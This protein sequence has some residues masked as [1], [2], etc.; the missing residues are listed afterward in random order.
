MLQITSRSTCSSSAA[1]T[2]REHSIKALLAAGPHHHNLF[3]PMSKPPVQFAFGTLHAAFRSRLQSSP[4]L[5]ALWSKSSGAN[6]NCPPTLPMDISSREKLYADVKNEKPRL[7][8]ALHLAQTMAYA[9][10]LLRFY[11]CGISAVW[12]NTK[13]ARRLRRRQYKIGPFLDRTGND[14]AI[15]V[16]R[17]RVL[18]GIMAQTLYMDGVQR[19]SSATDVIRHDST[20]E[21]TGGSNGGLFQMLRRDFQLLHRAPQDTAK[22]PLF[23]IV[24]T[25]FGEMTPLLCWAVPEIMPLTC[26]LPLLLPRV[27]RAEPLKQLRG[28]VQAE[29]STEDY[30][31]KTAFN[32][33]IAHVRAIATALR[34]KARHLPLWVYPEQIL[35]QRVQD[36]FN[37]LCVDNYYLS[38]LNG[39]GNLWN[40]STQELVLACL[41]R[42]LITDLAELVR[43]QSLGTL[44]ERTSSLDE[45]RL[46]LMQFIANAASANVG[47]LG[48]ATMM[49][50]PS[51]DVVQ[52][53]N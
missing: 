31:Q 47:Y 26:C 18:V 36:Y 6:I 44:E 20:D 30:A 14:G 5:S 16:P 52:W 10:Q 27:W 45:L 13:E 8:P 41:E 17:F 32:L 19:Q 1:T 2:E 37:Y 51:T 24:A 7:A 38:G 23:A 53:R 35:R 49:E 46:K 42:N 12:S 50:R 21:K 34:L 29:A 22:L 28:F 48:V 15:S 39:D 4:L 9:K 11:R 33:P 3:I 25:L 43:I 40:L